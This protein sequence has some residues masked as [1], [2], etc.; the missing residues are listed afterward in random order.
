MSC[1]RLQ[2]VVNIIILL[3]LLWYSVNSGERTMTAEGTTRL[4]VL[5]LDSKFYRAH[6]AEHGKVD[7]EV[8]ATSPVMF[9]PT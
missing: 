7:L 2:G 4:Q 6:T 3:V 5:T 8:S 1:T 9:T